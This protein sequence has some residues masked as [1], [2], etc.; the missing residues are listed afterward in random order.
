MS[1]QAQFWVIIVGLAVGTFLLRSIPLWAYGRRE[2]PRWLERLL[3]HVPAAAL[4]ALIVPSALYSRADGVYTLAP[5]RTIAAVVAL[6][7][8]LK[9]RNI[10][11][12]I[13]AGMITLWVVQALM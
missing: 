1:T 8:A 12:V 11:A 13:A 9:F 5:E 6:L 7:V 10:I 4:T 3:R 2:M